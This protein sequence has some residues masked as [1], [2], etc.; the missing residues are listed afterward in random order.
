MKGVEL[1]MWFLESAVF[2]FTFW[3]CKCKLS[4]ER[5]AMLKYFRVSLTVVSAIT[6]AL[7]GLQVDSQEGEAG[8]AVF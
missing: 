6:D 5:S 7:T 8:W 4:V 1:L 2:S 3:Q